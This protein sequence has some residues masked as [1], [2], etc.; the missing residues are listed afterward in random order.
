MDILLLYLRG[1]ICTSAGEYKFNLHYSHLDHTWKYTLNLRESK[2]DVVYCR[3]DAG[4]I[5]ASAEGRRQTTRCISDKEAPLV[6]SLVSIP[7]ALSNI[8]WAGGFRSPL[9]WV[10][11]NSFLSTFLLVVMLGRFLVILWNWST[12]TL[13]DEASEL[14]ICNTPAVLAMSLP[15]SHILISTTVFI[16]NPSVCPLCTS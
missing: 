7:R 11:I 2:C 6:V 16:N 13:K 4:Q 12:E 8:Q 14:L 9:I 5:K 10:W 3:F 1:I 15:C